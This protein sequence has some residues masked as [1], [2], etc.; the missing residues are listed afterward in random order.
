MES[1]KNSDHFSVLR[2]GLKRGSFNDA[3]NA[4]GGSSSYEY[5][6]F[7]HGLPLHV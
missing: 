2:E 6:N 7:V 3:I 4:W 5:A 1:I